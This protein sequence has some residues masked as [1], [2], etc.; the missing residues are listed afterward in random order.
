MRTPKTVANLGATLAVAVVCGAS[1]AQG[2]TV[3]QN[4]G[5]LVPVTGFTALKTSE[6][7]DEI[8]LAGVN[9]YV[10]KFTFSYIADILNSPNA[11]ATITMYKKDGPLAI[12]GSAS[13]QMPK[14]VLWQSGP[15]AL[16]NGVHGLDLTPGV[17]VPD[18]IVWTVKFSGLNALDYA[19]L[20]LADTPTI[21]GILPGRDH[22]VVGSY[23]D[24]WLKRNPTVDDSWALNHL[25]TA[26]VPLGNFYVQID[27]VPEPGTLA[28]SAFGA[29]VLWRM[30][31]SRRA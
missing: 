17:F 3:Y 1:V 20:L 11:T 10:D 23:E 30:M 26:S 24:F 21:G 19:S 16:V 28:L 4:T 14:T 12:P 31:K 25:G 13:T 15:Y 5:T 18:T 8:T 27:A 29:A 9:R 22:P 6:Y 2:E 7:G